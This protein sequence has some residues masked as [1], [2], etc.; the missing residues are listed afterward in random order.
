MAFLIRVSHATYKAST[1]VSW[2]ISYLWHFESTPLNLAFREFTVSPLNKCVSVVSVH[3][4]VHILSTCE[5]LA[6]SIVYNIIVLFNIIELQFPIVWEAN[7]KTDYYN[8]R[9]I[10][11]FST[12]TKD[13]I[14]GHIC[15]QFML[16]TDLPQNIILLICLAM[17]WNKSWEK[18]LEFE[19]IFQIQINLY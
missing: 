6:L 11:F 9:V 10:Q 19:A 4:S 16:F 12:Q 5:I 18:T 17:E 3:S 13:H 8:S 15:R 1:K 7:H 14:I 2:F